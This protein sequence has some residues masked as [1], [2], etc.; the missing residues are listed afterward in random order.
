MV[1]NPGKTK[2]QIPLQATV[3]IIQKRKYGTV[4]SIFNDQI[5]EKN[6]EFHENESVE[7]S[8]TQNSIMMLSSGKITFSTYSR[9]CEQYTIK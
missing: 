9:I 1:D 2:K 8:D 4:N 7:F 5:R 3:V 6:L